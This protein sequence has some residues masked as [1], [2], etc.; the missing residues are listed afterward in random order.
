LRR[1]PVL[2][3]GAGAYPEAVRPQLGTPGVPGAQYV[4]HNTF[5]SVL[6]E[7]GA[8]GFAVYALMLGTVAMYVWTLP[9][10]ERALWAIMLAVWT[11]GVSTLTWEHYKP[12]WLIVGLIMTEWGRPWRTAGLQG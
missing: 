2:G 12:G 7:C 8:I 5:L 4:A 9:S 3:I 1:H 11:V 10:A 6:V